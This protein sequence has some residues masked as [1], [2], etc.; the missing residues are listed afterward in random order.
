M[1]FISLMF[2]LVCFFA[3]G[4]IC[5]AEPL[6]SDI[7]STQIQSSATYYSYDYESRTLTI[8]GS[9][10]VPSFTNSSGTSTSQPWFYWRSDGSIEHVVVEEGITSLGNYCLYSVGTLDVSLPSTLEKI[11]SNTFGNM[12]NCKTFDLPSS[13]T[14]ISDNA[15]KSSYGL[16]SIVIPKSVV[17]I[18]TSAFEGCFN[19]SSVS[20]EDSK[21]NVVISRRAFYQCPNLKYVSIPKNASL[22]SYSFGFYEQSAGSV[23]DDAILGVYRDSP[24]YTYAVN[25][26]VS[27]VI[28]DSISIEQGESIGYEFFNDTIDSTMTFTFTP[29]VTEYYEFFSNGDSDVACRLVD[30]MGNTVAQSDNVSL[31]DTD[32]YICEA[33][34]AGVQYRFEV[35]TN[36]YAGDFI[37][38]LMPKNVDSISCTV[39]RVELSAGDR[40]NGKYDVISR[41]DGCVIT[42]NYATGFSE[43]FAF[44]NNGMYRERAITYYDNQDD[45]MWLCG[46]NTA[47]INIGDY[48]CRII[49]SIAHS[50]NSTVVE[51]TYTEKG[52]TIYSCVGCD[53]VYYSDYVASLGMLVKGRVVL[54]E[55]PD[56]THAHN[57]TLSLINICV[58]DDVKAVTD[59][60]G[61]FEFLVDATTAKIS[62]NGLFAIPRD[63]ALVPNNDGVADVGDIAIMNFDYNPDGYINAKDFSLIRSIY[64]T[65]DPECDREYTQLDYNH[66]YILNDD[67][68]IGAGAVNFYTHG[69]V[70]ESIYNNLD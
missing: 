67:D 10:A 44:E 59:N 34:E 36:N 5:H 50:Y 37:V 70:D 49:V 23:Y 25:N 68:W 18:G 40:V 22:Y 19:L 6:T 33:L 52:Y 1:C 9:G 56:G 42:F 60:D 38:T 3:T 24:A 28:L 4:V 69:K 20:F 7:E 14:G 27:Y 21:S 41:L 29:S 8:G 31:I 65:L 47:Y 61:K 55:A 57:F 43:S 13:M 32:F 66:D 58:G 53:D 15:F 2:A 62:I 30:N 64:Q 39:N 48:S 26:V 45:S 17:T 46:E 11:G 35:S 12:K 63:V 54:M 16:E 51:P